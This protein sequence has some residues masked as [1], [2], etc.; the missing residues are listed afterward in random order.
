MV[1]E[2][3][4]TGGIRLDTD[5]GTKV[6]LKYEGGVMG[7][8]KGGASRSY[9]LSVPATRSEGIFNVT[10]RRSTSLPLRLVP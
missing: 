4:L 2:I 5:G 7:L 9:D 1:V 6:G 3:T 10:P 8:P